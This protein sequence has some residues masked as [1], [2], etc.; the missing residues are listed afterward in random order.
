MI[1]N[2]WLRAFSINTD[3][4]LFGFIFFPDDS[5]YISVDKVLD[6]CFWG[7]L[8]SLVFETGPRKP[9]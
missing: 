7:D 3:L 1:R 4:F 6:F 9:G 2:C 8:L 5:F